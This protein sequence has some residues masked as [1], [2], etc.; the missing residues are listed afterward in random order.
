MTTRRDFLK[1][2]GL[3][4]AALAAGPSVA[5]PLVKALEAA[6]PVAV[7]A[8]SSQLIFML[9][10]LPSNVA[11]VFFAPTA[12]MA[13]D[14]SK[15]MMLRPGESIEFD[16][17]APPTVFFDR[18]NLNDKIQIEILGFGGGDGSGGGEYTQ[19]HVE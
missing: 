5:A 19:V 18:E 15:A 1:A 3:T 2:F 12:D 16:I 10:A 11:N 6:A 7:K 17:D 14:K 9:R 8:S 4:A 13:V